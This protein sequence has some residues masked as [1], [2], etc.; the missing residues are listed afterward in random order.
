MSRADKIALVLAL[1]AVAASAWVALQIF[2]GLPHLE[3]EFAYLWQAQVIAGGHLTLPSPPDPKSFLV[4]FV[5]DHAGQRFGKYPIGWPVVLAVGELLDLRWLV[6]PLLA[7][8][9]V[10][11]TY[12]LGKKTFG[13]PVALLA[14]GLTLTS[15]FFLMNSGSL[16]SHPWGLALALGFVIAWLDVIEP[17]A[18]LPGW[19]PT[20]SAALTLGALTLTRPYTALGVAIPFGVQ[21]LVLLFRGS[22][23]IKKRILIV[24][25]ITLVVAGLH[26]AWQFAV[27]GNLLLN[28]YELWWPYD[29]VGFGPGHGVAEGGHTLALARSGLKVSLRSGA[30]D[31]FGWL[32]Y[33]WLFL[34]FGLYA[35]RKKYR[36]WPVVAVFPALALLY[37]AYWVGAWAYGP[38]YYYEGLFGLTLLSAAGI[39]WLAGWPLAAGQPWRGYTGRA[40]ARPLAVT[41]LLA[42]LLA[43]NLIFYLPQRLGGMRGLYGIERAQVTPFLSEKAQSVAPALVV[44]KTEDWRQY[45]A[46]LD[47]SSPYLD[48]PIIFIWGRGERSE[49][50]VARAFPQRGI[51]YYFPDQP[52]VMYLKRLPEQTP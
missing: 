44:V 27:T 52:G 22:S 45:G 20:L 29:K 21:G 13:E 38:R 10:W 36:L 23:L 41:A 37:A 43:A 49:A 8:L 16:L 19:L 1:L 40:R 3:D 34:P 33:S 11:L 50:L 47:L 5:V 26:F 32:K 4:P 35:I 17:R 15:P 25:V 42:L 30:R 46:L 6:N 12:R 14:A 28:P 31:L 48:T 39:A 24:G 51:Y 7:G 9:A 2:E 18:D